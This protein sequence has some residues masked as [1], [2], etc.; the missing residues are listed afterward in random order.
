MTS[1]V[2]LGMHR[3]GTSAITRAL[4][5]LGAELGPTEDVGQ[6]WERGAMRLQ[7]DALLAKFGG[8]WDC[9]GVMPDSWE[10]NESVTEVEPGAASAIADYG[11]PEVLLWKDPRAS[12]TLPFWRKHLGDDPIAI[13]IY[14]HPEEVWASLDTRNGFGPGL[15][16]A[17]W[18]RYNS[19]ALRYA[20]G[21]R[22]VVFAYSE[23]VKNQV[24]IMTQLVATLGKWGV[25]LRDPASTDMELRADQQHHNAPE[26][27]SHPSATESQ[28]TLFASLVAS[29]GFHDSFSPPATMD[30]SP[31]SLELIEM[32]RQFRQSRREL[33]RSQ[34]A[35]RSLSGSR[36]KLLSLLIR[37][38][39]PS[40]NPPIPADAHA[41]KA[42][43]R[44]SPSA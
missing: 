6:Y 26:H 2:I 29:R 31:L 43:P 3:S 36:R 8:A 32:R 33:W 23:L 42:G 35:H 40:P 15:S 18:E 28:Q 14:R 44:R 17:L 5:L 41:S 20:S 24:E 4:N 1:I 37:P 16:F 27:F 19:D 39:R 7:C 22:T 9:P 11:D 13:I 10:T 25:S 21:L 12:L 34:S 30:P 38:E